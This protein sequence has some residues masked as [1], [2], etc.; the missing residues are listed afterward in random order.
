MSMTIFILYYKII[1]IKKLYNGLKIPF[2]YYFKD[3]SLS[4]ECQLTLLV[5]FIK[6]FKSIRTCQPLLQKKKKP[7]NRAI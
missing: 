6:A 7:I 5:L 2:L 1:I 3:L 4:L